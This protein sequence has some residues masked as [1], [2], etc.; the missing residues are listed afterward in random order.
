MEGRTF[1]E[2][3]SSEHKDY[4]YIMHL[5]YGS[6]KT[7]RERLWKC[8]TD[9]NMIGLDWYEVTRDWVTLSESEQQALSHR[10]WIRQ[11]NLFCGMHIG[12]YVVILNG[13]F[14]LLGI[15]RITESRH[16]F[17]PNLSSNSENPDRFFDHVR[18][19]VAW[20]KKYP[21]DGCPLTQQLTFDNTIDIVRSRTRSPRWKVLTAIDP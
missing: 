14:S 17:R 5:S 9:K 16:W 1:G 2:L 6:D 12:D 3:L 10:G 15:A 13:T 21:Y 4:F 19:H 7:Q 18:E 11:F 20:I 8:A